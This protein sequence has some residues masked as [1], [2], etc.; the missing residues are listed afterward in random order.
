MRRPA[1]S[2]AVDVERRRSLS[3]TP[4]GQNSSAGTGTSPS[5][6]M[7]SLSIEYPSHATVPRDLTVA[8]PR[9]SRTPISRA[10]SARHVFL[11]FVFQKS[12][13]LLARRLASRRL[14]SPTETS[15]GYEVATCPVL[16]AQ[17]A[18]SG[19]NL[20]S[21][22][23]TSAGSS[24]SH[25]RIHWQAFSRRGLLKP[26]LSSYENRSIRS[27]AAQHRISPFGFGAG[28]ADR[29]D[30]EVVLI[31]R[32]HPGGAGARMRM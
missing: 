18:F 21:G 32:Q 31:R 1:F 9:S 17:R 11:S 19:C 16:V 2:L 14:S 28:L 20:N 6:W 3:L 4:G 25:C 30:V 12:G 26:C 29:V 5:R 10:T 13:G 7:R 22:S 15:S 23:T 27:G 8:R 24:S